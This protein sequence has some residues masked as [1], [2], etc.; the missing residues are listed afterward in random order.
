MKGNFSRSWPLGY[1]P[2]PTEQEKKANPLKS[3]LTVLSDHATVLASA[4]FGYLTF[5]YLPLPITLLIHLVLWA[6]IAK[7]QRGLE[8]LLH[9]AAHTN[10]TRNVRLGDLLATFLAALPTGKTVKGYRKLHKTHHENYGTS[11]DNDRQD[12]EKL[13]LGNIRKNSRTM[14]VVDVLKC[15]PSYALNSWKTMSKSWK[16][17]AT[18]HLCVVILLCWFWGIEAG[19]LLWLVYWVVPYIFFLTPHRLVAESSEHVYNEGTT[20][21]ETTVTNCGLIQRYFVHPHNDG[22]HTLHHVCP[23]IPHSNLKKAHK[24]LLRD[25]P[26][27]YRARVRVRNKVVQS[28]F[29]GNQDAT[30]ESDSQTEQLH[31]GELPTF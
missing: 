27:G 25:D 5:L 8:N 14:F 15:L 13:G 18:F 22:Y 20:V 28:P 16:P 17:V 11:G 21:L 6:L 2:N 3:V 9:E 12:F 4:Y 7:A 24:R 23:T 19:V 29:S 1:K 10:W 26:N 30:L 31:G